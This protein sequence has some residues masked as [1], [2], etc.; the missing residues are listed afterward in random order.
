MANE[1]HVLTVPEKR[2]ARGYWLSAVKGSPRRS[3]RAAKYLG[4]GIKMRTPSF[5]HVPQLRELKRG[6]TSVGN[7]A[8]LG[9][10]SR[11]ENK[12]RKEAKDR[13]AQ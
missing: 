9:Y 7:V 5:D 4:C 10:P 8:R 1:R 11:V 6:G 13:D 3:L 12:E 2:T